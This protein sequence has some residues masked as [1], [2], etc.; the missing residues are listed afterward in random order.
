MVFCL[1]SNW[2]QDGPD[3]T[4]EIIAMSFIFAKTPRPI[5]KSLKKPAGSVILVRGGTGSFGNRVASHLLKQNPVQISI[6]NRLK[7]EGSVV[8]P[9]IE[10]PICNCDML[11]L[12]GQIRSSTVKVRPVEAKGAVNQ[13]LIPTLTRPG[14][15]QQLSELKTWYGSSKPAGTPMQG[16][17]VLA[18]SL[19]TSN[20]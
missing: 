7:K 14:L 18:V 12:M 4:Q 19:R 2:G 3:E 9:G 5:M 13:T 10:P 11:R 20:L 1:V 8:Q 17:A 15:E 16:S 6:Y